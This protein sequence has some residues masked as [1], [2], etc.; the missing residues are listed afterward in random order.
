MKTDCSALKGTFI[1]SAGAQ[2]T[3][4]KTVWEELKESQDREK[5]YEKLSSVHEQPLQ[6]WLPALP[7]QSWASQQPITNLGGAHGALLSAALVATESPEERQVNVFSCVPLMK[8]P[9]SNGKSQIHSD[10]EVP[11]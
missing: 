11:G 5:G 3:S 1:T 7:K 6:L 10:T 9:G 8:P 4:W 2:R